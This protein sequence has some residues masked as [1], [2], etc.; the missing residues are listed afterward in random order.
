MWGTSPAPT[1]SFP[2]ARSNLD[3]C[4]FSLVLRQCLPVGSYK[5]QSLFLLEEPVNSFFHCMLMNSLPGAGTLMSSFSHRAPGLAQRR[6]MV[7]LMVAVQY[8]VWSHK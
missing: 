6:Q 1:I 8:A 2:T 5:I 4:Y 3:P 7:K